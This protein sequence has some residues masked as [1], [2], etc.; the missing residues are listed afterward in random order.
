[1]HSIL[2]DA[3]NVNTSE[4]IFPSCSTLHPSICP[5]VHQNTVLHSSNILHWILSKDLICWEFILN[6]DELNTFGR[7]SKC[8]GAGR[9]SWLYSR[10]VPARSFTAAVICHLE[11]EV[12][13][14]WQKEVRLCVVRSL[15]LG[16]LIDF[17][18]QLPDLFVNYTLWSEVKSCLMN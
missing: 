4:G 7:H 3:T 5:S 15:L 1:M 18:W 12:G 9:P 8:S 13:G 11:V 17:T 6:A 2:I 14:S 16:V 10:L